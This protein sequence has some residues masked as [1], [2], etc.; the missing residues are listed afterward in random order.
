MAETDSVK[1]LFP[2]VQGCFESPCENN[3]LAIAT[4]YRDLGGSITVPKISSANE[5]TANPSKF[6]KFAHA[7]MLEIPCDLREHT[8]GEH[9]NINSFSGAL[10][11]EIRRLRDLGAFSKK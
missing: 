4:I 2:A 3:R 10:S 5:D 8:A 6:A 7:A 11:D 1:L 9:G